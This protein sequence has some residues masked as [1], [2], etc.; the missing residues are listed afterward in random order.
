MNDICNSKE[1]LLRPSAVALFGRKVRLC[2]FDF[3]LTLADGS[4]W[5]VQSYREVLSRNGL[6]LPPEQCPGLFQSGSCICLAGRPST[7]P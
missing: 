3:D 6:P 4:P 1:N 2:I 5:I 7:F